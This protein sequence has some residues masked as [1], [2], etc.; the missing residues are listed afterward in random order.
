MGGA[1][2]QLLWR[3]HPER[4][5]GLVLCATAARFATH[6]QM[7]GPVGTLGYGLALA[8]SGIPAGVRR[9]GFGVLLRRRT[10]A[11]G[12]APWV[13]AEWESNDPAALAQAGFALGRFDARDW[14]A[15]VDVPTSV[16]VTTLDMTVSPRR[17]WELQQAIPGAAAFSVAGDHRAC[18]DEAG[19]FASSLVV[20]CRTVLAEAVT[21]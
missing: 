16:V 21:T 6:P 5:S 11:Q 17:Q 8:L 13:I 14:I 20:A 7:R 10:A 18:A 1:V 4:V 9:Q 3:R 12:L 19:H 2:A 15:T